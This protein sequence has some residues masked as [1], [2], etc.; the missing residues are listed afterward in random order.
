MGHVSLYTN[1]EYSHQSKPRAMADEEC[2]GRLVDTQADG[3]C[4][5][6]T[7]NLLFTKCNI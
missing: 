6:L 5:G 2:K 3:M 4:F 7:Y 1:I